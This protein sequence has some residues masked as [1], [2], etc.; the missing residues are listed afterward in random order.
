MVWLEIYKRFLNGIFQFEVNLNVVRGIL[1]LIPGTYNF[2]K[3]IVSE[4][5]K[6]RDYFTPL[7]VSCLVADLIDKDPWSTLAFIGV[8]LIQG[9]GSMPLTFHI[10]NFSIS[11]SLDSMIWGVIGLFLDK[12]DD[13]G[14]R[15]RRKKKN[16]GPNNGEN[17][18]NNERDNK[19]EN[20]ENIENNNLNDNI[21]EI[22]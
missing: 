11:I 20:E 14:K 4:Q 12:K 21:N 18:E 3:G 6:G 15:R 22:K 8:F 5:Y 16:N 7:H 2:I 1:W 17:V 10:S 19:N 9:F 13:D